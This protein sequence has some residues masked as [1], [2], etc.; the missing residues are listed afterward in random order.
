M[1]GEKPLGGNDSGQVVKH[2]V[3]ANNLERLSRYLACTV[4]WLTPVLHSYIPTGLVP[5]GFWK[6]RSF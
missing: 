6:I 3:Y 2:F 5:T 4:S 1:A